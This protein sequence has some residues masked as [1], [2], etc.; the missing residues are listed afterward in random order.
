LCTE[1]YESAALTAELEERREDSFG[2]TLEQ[3]KDD[4]E[5]VSAT[6]TTT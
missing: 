3:H 2:A 1:H 6:V 4:S 5:L